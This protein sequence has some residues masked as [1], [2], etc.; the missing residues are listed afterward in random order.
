V[1]TLSVYLNHTALDTALIM[2]ANNGA[3]TLAQNLDLF[4]LA[5]HSFSAAHPYYASANLTGSTGR[6]DFSDGAYQLYTGIVDLTPAAFS[7]HATANGI[8][9][10][11][12]NAFRLSFGGKLTFDYAFGSVG[13]SI[14]GTGGTITD[15]NMQTLVPTTSSAYSTQLGNVTLS[16]HGSLLTNT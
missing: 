2:R 6:L 7:G 15:A 5:S 11:S 1:T 16:A 14:I 3:T 13:T 12:P 10:Y 4:F 9:E 8:E